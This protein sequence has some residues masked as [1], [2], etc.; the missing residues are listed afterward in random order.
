MS[1]PL[2]SLEQFFSG[3]LDGHGLGWTPGVGDGQGGLACCSPWG[4]KELD[5]TKVTKKK[6][7]IGLLTMPL[8]S[9]KHLALFTLI[10]IP[11]ILLANHALGCLAFLMN[12]ISPLIS[13]VEI[14]LEMKA[15]NP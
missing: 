2:A 11:S 8:L 5:T 9:L 14:A 4:C 1:S 12:L 13:R 10:P 15:H 3:L 7:V 6:S